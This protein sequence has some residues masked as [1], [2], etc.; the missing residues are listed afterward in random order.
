MLKR[1]I[2]VAHNLHL[3]V[4]IWN[5]IHCEVQKM[6]LHFLKLAFLTFVTVYANNS[7]ASVIVFSNGQ[8]WIEQGTLGTFD[9]GTN[10]TNNYVT[11]ICNT[12]TRLC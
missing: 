6:R 8:G 5:L 7:I 3:S 9:N 2:I 11:N 4:T 12:C 10:P 1:F